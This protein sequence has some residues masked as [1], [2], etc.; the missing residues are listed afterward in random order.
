MSNQQNLLCVDD[1]SGI[2]S[3]L[4]RALHHE[5]FNVLTASNS[6][7]ALQV[8]SEHEI[9]VILVDQHM[10][11]I[12]GLNLIK[13]IKAQHPFIVSVI[14]SGLVDMDYVLAAIN[15]GDVQRFLAKPWN[16]EELKTVLRQCFHHFD[17]VHSNRQLN[18]VVNQ[19]KKQLEN[20]TAVLKGQG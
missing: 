7:D 12:D 14:L 9:Q 6:S 8:L 1:E 17:L 13:K 20:L 11:E 4:V 15:R 5:D 19:Q 10:P 3:S 2:L 18:D 16:N